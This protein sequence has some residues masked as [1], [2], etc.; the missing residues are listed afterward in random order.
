MTTPTPMLKHILLALFMVS[1]WAL[2]STVLAAQVQEEA[3][4]APVQTA[5]PAEQ[6][7][8]DTRADCQHYAYHTHPNYG[9]DGVSD[10]GFVCPL[11]NAVFKGCA[12][13]GGGACRHLETGRY[14]SFSDCAY[15]GTPDNRYEW[16]CC[17]EEPVNCDGGHEYRTHPNYGGDGVSDHSFTC[18]SDMNAVFVNCVCEIGGAGKCTFDEDGSKISF[19]RCRYEGQPDNLYQWKCCRYVNKAPDASILQPRNGD[20]FPAGAVIVFQGVG[21]DPEDGDLTANIV[22]TS[23]EDG[24]L[25]KG[26]TISRSLSDG[27]H[28][29]TAVVVDSEGEIAVAT[30]NI[31]V[32]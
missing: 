30:A 23:S 22:W 3:Q 19:S 11:G 31:T 10:H 18:Q 16:M 20:T 15:T 28:T 14:I 13:E 25:G 27:A 2:P 5:D 32:G 1:A 9:G 6:A 17:T 12:C 7:D 4:E 26:G 24:E 8:S 29:I 21:Q